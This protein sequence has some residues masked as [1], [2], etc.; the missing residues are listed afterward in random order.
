MNKRTILGQYYTPDAIAQ[1]VVSKALSLEISPNRVIE[2]AAGRG[3]LLSALMQHSGS[4]SVFAV[5]IDESNIQYLDST[6]TGV[7][8]FHADATKPLDFLDA[9]TFDLGLGNPPFLANNIVDSYTHK[10]LLDS[11]GLNYSIGSK[12]RSEYIF[13]AQYLNLIKPKGMLAIIVPETII[14]GVKA[15]DFRRSLTEKYN[16]IEVLE[17][18][19]NLFS[20]TEAKTYVLFIK[21]EM[22]Q[23]NTIKLSNCNKN[24]V[25]ES[26]DVGVDRTVLRMDYNY[27]FLNSYD[28]SNCNK[29]KLSDFATITRGKYT[30]KELKSSRRK[31]THSTNFNINHKRVHCKKNDLDDIQYGDLIMC[32]VGTRV[33]G[34]VREYTGGNVV[35]SDCIYRIRFSRI[36][37]KDKFMNYVKSEVGYN[38]IKAITRGVCSRYITK[39][40]LENFEFPV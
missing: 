17:L 27:H 40:D 8:T 28:R 10:L 13:I 20:N 1:L 33:V 15:I 39:Q 3:H 31:Y 18:S 16:V 32:R 35:Y 24:S 34:N 30:H 36:D 19:A 2:L 9:I 22:P 14:S 25:I 37:I 11:F 26:I 6:F 29:V 7:T 4:F 23:G 38:S 5:D 21:N 12:T